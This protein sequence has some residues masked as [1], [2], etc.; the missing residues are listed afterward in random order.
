ME[1][2]ITIDLLKYLFWFAAFFVAIIA[3]VTKENKYIPGS[4]QYGRRRGKSKS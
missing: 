1:E 4:R 3:I 2:E